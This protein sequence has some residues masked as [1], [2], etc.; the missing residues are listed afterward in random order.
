MIARLEAGHAIAHFHH[1]AGT[2]MAQHRGKHALGII[3]AQRE[4]IGMADAGMGDLHQH[5]AFLRR[6]DVDLDDFQRF[7]GGE[8]YGGT[9]FHGASPA[10]AV[11]DSGK[12]GFTFPKTSHGRTATASTGSIPLPGPDFLPFPIAQLITLWRQIV[13]YPTL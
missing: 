6:S 9:G 2:L 3:P 12:A 1:H 11:L 5:F 4:G 7:S 8:G 10:G 13:T